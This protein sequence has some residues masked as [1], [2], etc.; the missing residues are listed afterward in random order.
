VAAQH[1][2]DIAQTTLA[3]QNLGEGLPGALMCP[4]QVMKKPGPG[5]EY[6]LQGPAPYE[7]WHDLGID[8][9]LI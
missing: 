9:S 1:P 2:L 7:V 5:I 6:L 4:H 3:V 8:G